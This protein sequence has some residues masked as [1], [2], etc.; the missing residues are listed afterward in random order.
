MHEVAL[1]AGRQ[2]PDAEAAEFHVEEFAD[3]LAGREGVDRSLGQAAVGDGVS[4]ESVALT[5][6]NEANRPHS[7]V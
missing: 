1:A 6:R 3:G 4:P 7:G 2:D 5:G